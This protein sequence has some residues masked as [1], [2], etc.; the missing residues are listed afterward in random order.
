MYPV[1]VLVRD[2]VTTSTVLPFPGHPHSSYLNGVLFKNPELKEDVELNFPLME[3]LFH[4][5]LGLVK[6]LKDR[7]NVAD[8]AIVWSLIVGYR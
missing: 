2:I 8:G 3:E 1:R 6:L 7:F 4:L 5:Y